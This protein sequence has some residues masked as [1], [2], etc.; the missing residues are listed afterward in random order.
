MPGTNAS[1]LDPHDLAAVKLLV[2]R[3]KDL[4]LV[5]DLLAVRLL[6]PALI[7]ARINLLPL[8]AEAVPRI[9]AALNGLS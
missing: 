6:D 3:P 2:A 5:R 9:L 1:A 4:A 8:P 7:R